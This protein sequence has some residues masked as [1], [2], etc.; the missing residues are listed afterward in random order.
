M[1]KTCSKCSHEK[2]LPSFAES[3]FQPDGHCGWCR[4]C[5]KQYGLADFDNTGNPIKKKP[6]KKKSGIVLCRDM[7]EDDNTANGNK[8]CIRCGFLFEA[9]LKHFGLN[10]AR[11][12]HLS[13]RCKTCE[14]II[15]R[16]KARKNKT[17]IQK[18]KRAYDEVGMTPAE[19]EQRKKIVE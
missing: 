6:K 17:Y 9:S 13:A 1:L 16:K 3:K 4:D 12:D 5:Q 2:P 8:G 19:I 14:G 15:A 18:H 11:K 7:G 10:I